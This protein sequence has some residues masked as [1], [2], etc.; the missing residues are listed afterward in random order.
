ME[1]TFENKQ[2]T[3]G[4]PAEKVSAHVF[5][6]L[7]PPQYTHK[8]KTHPKLSQTSVTLIFWQKRLHLMRH[9]RM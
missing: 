7:Q 8:H 3:Q 1:S 9:E 6:H 5:W 4:G 2:V